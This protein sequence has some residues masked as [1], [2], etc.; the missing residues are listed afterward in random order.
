MLL[1]AIGAGFSGLISSL[2]KKFTD[3]I[4]PVEK[5]AQRKHGGWQ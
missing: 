4:I 1:Q 5:P 2:W 3:S